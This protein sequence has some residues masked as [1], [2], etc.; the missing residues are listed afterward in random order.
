MSEPQVRVMIRVGATGGACASPKCSSAEPTTADAPPDLIEHLRRAP[1]PREAHLLVALSEGL[2]SPT[3]STTVVE[4]D[5]APPPI[6]LIA[7]LQ[8]EVSRAAL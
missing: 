6:D 2:S 8:H 5:G 1:D 3:E 4:D 7:F